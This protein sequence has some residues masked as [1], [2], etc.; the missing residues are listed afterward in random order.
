[1][2]PKQ[3]AAERERFEATMRRGEIIDGYLGVWM[4]RAELAHAEQ[5]ALTKEN[6]ALKQTVKEL[7]EYAHHKDS[8]M[9]FTGS[10]VVRGLTGENAGRI[11]D[12][13]VKC[14]CGLD[15]ALAK[16]QESK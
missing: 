13:D 3:E 6:A 15:A 4:A 10:Y 8:C 1:M 11:I 2:T 7:A 9:L 14:T 12:S 16:A 5:A